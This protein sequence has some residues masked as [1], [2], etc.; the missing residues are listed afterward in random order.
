MSVK[1]TT[2]FTPTPWR[3][4][5]FEKK[6]LHFLLNP[7]VHY[8]VPEPHTHPVHTLPPN[9]TIIIPPNQ[10]RDLSSGLFPFSLP[11]QNIT[12]A[13][14]SIPCTVDFT[15][16]QNHNQMTFFTPK[17]LSSGTVLIN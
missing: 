6:I 7:K 14:S 10:R 8:R 12:Y 15:L 9:Y 1:W 13:F 11:N 16:Q 2:D 3:R 17:L 4:T 5:L